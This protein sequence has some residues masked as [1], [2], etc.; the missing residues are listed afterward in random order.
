MKTDINGSV[1]ML[2][3]ETR[4]RITAAGERLFGRLG[5]RIAGLK[6][7]V[8]QAAPTGATTCEVTVK[9]SNRFQILARHRDRDA[10]KAAETALERARLQ[11]GRALRGSRKSGLHGLYTATP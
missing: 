5:R 2:D 3:T 6:V 4:E 1:T 10:L 7:Q 9:T 11:V 8:E